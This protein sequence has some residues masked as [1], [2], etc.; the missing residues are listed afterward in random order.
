MSMSMGD[1]SDQAKGEAAHR[2]CGAARRQAGADG[3]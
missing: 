3:L 2:R 1:Y